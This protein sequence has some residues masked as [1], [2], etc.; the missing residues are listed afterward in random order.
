MSVT[1]EAILAALSHVDDPDLKKDLVTLNMIKN[2]QVEDTKVQFDVELTTPACPMKDMIQN[3]C[4]NAVQHFVSKDLEVT[5]N[6]TS[7]VTTNRQEKE[8]LPGVKNIIA[9]ASGKGGVGKSTVAVNLARSLADSGASVGILD[10]DIYGPSLP[11]MFGLQG[12]KPGQ[13]EGKME[14]LVKDGIKVI[15]I[16]FLVDENQAIVWRGP[17]ASSAIKQFTTDVNWGELDYLILDL[18][19]G[20]GDIH[21]TIAKQVP[22]SGS[23]IVTTPQS[24]ALADCKKA[25]NMFLNPNIN[26]PVFGIVEN[27]SY[28]SP[29]DQPDKRYYLFGKDGGKE[30]AEQFNL[31]LLGQIPLVESIR[32][33]GDNGTAIEKTET[34][35][36]AYDQLAGEL[37]RQVAITN[38]VASLSN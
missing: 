11:T 18:P 33:S 9:V 1:K 5:P 38:S 17:M 16:G 10:A 29:E 13:V 30:I 21:L 4:V 14:P 32:T 15:S 19:P 24:V 22:V 3:A 7:R 12:E 20:T 37:A 23:V 35:K 34:V 26:V 8:V 25:V 31:P 6:M 27:M 28:F 2:I 36:A